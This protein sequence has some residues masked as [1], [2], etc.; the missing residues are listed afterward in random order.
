MHITLQLNNVFLISVLV[1]LSSLLEIPKHIQQA[2]G[3]LL[4]SYGIA[5]PTRF[6]KKHR[7]CCAVGTAIGSELLYIL[8]KTTALIKEGFLLLINIMK[9]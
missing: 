2:T 7:K 6:K 1:Q 3:H 4:V 5:S 9:I 8:R